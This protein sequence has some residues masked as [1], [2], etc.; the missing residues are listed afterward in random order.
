MVAA[1]YEGGNDF[2][3]PQTLRRQEYW[4][5][6]SGATGQFYGNKYT[7]PLVRGWQRHL[8]TVGSRQLSFVT[9]LFAQRRWYDL[10][11]DIEHRVLV[12]GYGKRKSDGSVNDSDYVTAAATRDGKLLIAYLPGGTLISVDLTELADGVRGRWYDPTNGRYT[13]ID[14]SALAGDG[15]REL[16]PPGVNGGGDKDW[17]LVL[18]AG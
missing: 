3:G 13:A 5:L 7:W 18:M 14:G 2:T 10:V 15:T 11:P 1:N 4:S 9:N 16:E 6:L 17:A 8:D 12:S